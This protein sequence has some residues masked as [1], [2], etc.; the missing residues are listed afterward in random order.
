MAVARTILALVI[1]VSL[2]LLPVMGGFAAASMPVEGATA[3]MEPMPDCCD[4]DDMPMDHKANDCQT[5]PG[6]AAKC[7][8]FCGVIVWGSIIHPDVACPQ[9]MPMIFVLRSHVGAPPF[10]PPRV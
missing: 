10:R 7:F 1:A 4:H 8:C 3:A 5:M 6:C 9:P 2:A